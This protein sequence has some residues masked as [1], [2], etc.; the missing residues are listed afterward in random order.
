MKKALT[1]AGSDSGGGA[2][3]QQDLR[4]FSSLK[5]YGTSVI[6]AVTAQN[7]IGVQ[8][9]EA[10]STKLVSKQI[11]SV[12]EDVKTDAV[13]TGM[14]ANSEITGLVFRKLKQYKVRNLVVD[15]VMVSTSSNRLLDADAIEELRDLMSIATL[16]TPNISEAEAL[17]G[18]KVKTHKD[19]EKAAKAIGGDCVV[20][21]GH[22][23]AVD[24][25]H[26]K[27]RI[28]RFKCSAR[29]DA[30]L[31]GAGCAFSAAIAAHLA[32]GKEVVDAVGLAKDYVDGAIG[33]NFSIGAGAR[34][35]DT[36][37][38]KLGRTYS[39][40]E[41]DSAI[42]NLEDAV[43]RFTSSRNAYKLIPQVG[44]NIAMGLKNAKKIDDVAGMTGRIVRDRRRAVAVGVIDYGGSS[45]VGRIVLT[46]MRYNVN[47]R[48]AMNV[49]FSDEIV[50]ACKH[51]GLSIG[52][53][54]R[55]K[56][57]ADTKTMERG[58][59]GAVKAAGL[60]PDIVYD[61]G[62]LGKEAMVRIIGK[63]AQE[64]VGIALKIGELIE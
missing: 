18:I 16:S 33:R 56:Q 50:S 55:V 28:Y 13:K 21:G 34:V 59:S 1:I 54:D 48:A 57:P 6:T 2:G 23:D 44:T 51:L 24:V 49:R 40:K 4:V 15:P 35:L 45:H 37:G 60:V 42:K 46:V 27:G 61:C 36:G 12:M 25:L 8:G 43:E 7:T 38:I 10:V 11:D 5:V 39:E 26:Y 64:V 58:T 19:M 31:H 63:D 22:L 9:F 20:K 62:G 17:T 3:I 32:R 30:R 47:K 14:L 53:F 41:K 52:S 29:V